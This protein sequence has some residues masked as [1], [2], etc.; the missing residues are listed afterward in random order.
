MFNFLEEND[1]DIFYI[2]KFYHYSIHLTLIRKSETFTI[3]LFPV[4]EKQS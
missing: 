1:Q 3:Y 4:L 2:P